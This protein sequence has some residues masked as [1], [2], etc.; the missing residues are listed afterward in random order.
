[1]ILLA[2]LILSAAALVSAQRT[3]TIDAK[4]EQALTS[5]EKTVWKNLADKKYDDFAGVL[6]DDFQAVYP[7]GV[8]N[9][10]AE[11]ASVKQ[12][13][14]KSAEISDIK[15]QMIDAGSAIVTA[16]VKIAVTMPDGKLMTQN[17]R[18]TSIVAKRGGKWL[19][20]YHSHI[21]IESM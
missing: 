12:I 21:P 1:M 8:F 14:F 3:Q 16:N 13:D 10:T 2:T 20:V 7:W 6:A 11:L 17:V 4:T 19:C 5:N 9:K 15:V 18:T